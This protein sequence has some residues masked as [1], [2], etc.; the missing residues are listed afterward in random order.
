[1]SLNEFYDEPTNLGF[2]AKYINHHI[3]VT[4]TDL[5]RRAIYTILQGEIPCVTAVVKMQFDVWLDDVLG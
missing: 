2:T 4:V 3:I 1:M 5:D